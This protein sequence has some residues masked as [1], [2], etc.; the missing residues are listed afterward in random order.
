MQE[1]KGKREELAVLMDSWRT[2]HDWKG[3]ETGLWM[4]RQD[5]KKRGNNWRRKKGEGHLKEMGG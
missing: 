5:T 3:K 2:G 4:Q 1:L